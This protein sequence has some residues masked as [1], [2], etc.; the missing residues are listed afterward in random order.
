MAVRCHDITVSLHGAQAGEFDRLLLVGMA[1]QL[2]LHLRGLATAVPYDLLR[3]IGLYLLHIPSTS[4]E[5]VVELLAEIDFLKLDR[6]GGTIRTVIPVIP[7]YEDLFSGVGEFIANKPL[8]E[9]EQLAIAVL[10]RLSRSPTA[11]QTLYSCGAEKRLLDRTLKVGMEGGY[12]IGRRARGRDILLTPIY[13]PE[14]GDAFAD[15]AAGAGSGTVARVISILAK[16]QGWP[17]RLIED[18]G[19]IGENLLTENERHVITE[20][21]KEGFSPPPTITT[22]HAG[23]NYFIFGPK[24]GIPN[25]PPQK[26]HIYENAMALVAAVRQGQLLP[27]KIR[28]RMPVA[29]LEALRDRKWLKAN[30]EALEQYRQLVVL[31]VGRLVHVSGARWYRFELIDT[32]ENLEAV[33]MALLLIKGEQLPLATNE[34]ITL[35]LQKGQEYVES[36]VSR[37]TLVKDCPVSIDPQVRA[38]IDNLLYKGVP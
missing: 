15:L 33:E 24:P 16:N 9:P 20:L 19:K 13:F 31:R 28:I 30:T 37:Q 11:R 7:F 4:F 18:S 23:S 35:A 27:E 5:R 8:S 2:A 34:E 22:T 10:D 32:P 29:L 6:Q 1:V 26:R 17:L 36:L 14:H 3:Q 21:A 38:E 12:L 25:L